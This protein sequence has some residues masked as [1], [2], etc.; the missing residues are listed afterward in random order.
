MNKVIKVVHY[1]VTGFTIQGLTDISQLQLPMFIIFL[2]FYII[3][4]LEN[5]SICGAIIVDS[6]L[7]T[8]MYMFLSSLSW[9]DIMCASNILPNL[10]HMLLLQ[11]KTI[12]FLGCITQMYFFMSITSTEV[13][14]L[15]AMAYDRYVAISFPLHY[16]IL[17]SLR[18][19]TAILITAWSI[20]FIDP[21]G[22]AALVSKLSFCTS[23]LIDHFFCDLNPLLKLSCSDISHLE[24][25]NYIE[26]S[27]L[28][29]STFLLT[30]ISY[31][32]IIS[33][34]LKIKSVEGRQKAFSTCTSHLTCV[35]IFYGSI[36]CLYMRPT[37]NYSP[38][39]DKFFALLY[40]IVVPIL[41][42]VIYSLKNQ[43]VKNALKKVKNKVAC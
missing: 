29:L 39:Q 1:N 15:G 13:L 8:P 5:L 27:L 10:L 31:I 20:G 11:E 42:P 40:S 14:V 37:S 34:I 7:H 28:G 43:D 16:F 2:L 3:I 38:K 33:A 9:I 30:L 6:H 35:T 36:L 24:Y 18:K 12:S 21:M 22:H 25:L 4:I 19:C 26:G 23:H 17:M 32:F 41:N